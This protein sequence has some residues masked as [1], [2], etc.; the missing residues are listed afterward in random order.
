MNFRITSIGEILHDVYPEYK[1]LG[2]APFNFIYHVW[3][4]NGQGNF[5]SKVGDDQNGREI[6]K[7]LKSK[8][9]DCKNISVDPH[10]PTGKVNLRLLEN[11]V[12]QFTISPESA[13]DYIELTDEIKKLVAKKT[14]LLYFGTLSQRSFTTRS[15]IEHL[16]NEKIKYFSDL[17]LRHSFFNEQMISTT[18]NKCNVIK[19]NQEELK[20]I[21]GLLFK[22]EYKI[23]DAAKRLVDEYNLDLLCITLGEEGA[24]LFSK[25]GSNKTKSSVKKI[26][27]TLGAGDAYSAILCLGYLHGWKIE[28]INKIANKFAGDIC[29]VEGALPADDSFYDKYKSAFKNN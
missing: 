15:T 19:T 22:R 10:Y 20:I 9:F 27:D 25:D 24:Y 12:P 1:K 8:K 23:K 16:L 28:K 21:T 18:F 5:V 29:T 13:W 26:V 3:K 4:L 11:K 2:G 14:D 17:N 7:F 6:L